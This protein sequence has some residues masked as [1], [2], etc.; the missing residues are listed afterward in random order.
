MCNVSL[1][2]VCSEQLSQRDP[3][4][5]S[6]S[7]WRSAANRLLRLYISAENPWES[8]LQI[9]TFIAKVFA[10]MWF[11]IKT[12][13]SCKNGAKHVKAYSKITISVERIEGWR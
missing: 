12:D 13:L 7:R 6:H 4:L 5:L 3:S 1:K 8:I 2:G 9:V 11:T 10:P